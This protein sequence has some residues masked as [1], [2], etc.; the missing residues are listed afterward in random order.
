MRV[1]YKQ[2]SKKEP[3]LSKDQFYIVIGMYSNIKETT[4]KKYIIEND[5]GQ[6][7]S[8]SSEL[9][10]VLNS[11][12]ST[13]WS[14]DNKE[15]L[16]PT[17]IAYKSFWED[18]YNDNSIAVS[19]FSEVKSKIYIEELTK[20][21]V[22]EL[23][24]NNDGKYVDII[25][26]GLSIFP[27]RQYIE[28]VVEYCKDILQNSDEME[29]LKYAFLFLVNFREISIENLFVEWAIDE[30]IN[31]SELMDIINKYFEKI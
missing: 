28:D 9:F 8:Y 13:F 31:C 14:C 27:Q 19:L 10:D 29:K 7:I 2:L 21:E 26:K 17:E 6:I 24:K 1:A 11:K 16:I 15:N 4:H 23:I 18:F 20:E 3:F 25:L 5:I 30:Y 12:N 22:K